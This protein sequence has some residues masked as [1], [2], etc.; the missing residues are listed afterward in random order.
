MKAPARNGTQSRSATRARAEERLR[1]YRTGALAPGTADLKRLVHELEVHQIELEMQNEQLRRTQTELETTRERLA[2]L[3]DAAPVGY[4]TID[5]SG[6]VH[7][8]N[9]TAARLLGCPRERLAGQGLFRFIAPESRDTF[10]FFCQSLAET[11][12]KRTVELRFQR[13]DRSTF[14]GW[15]ESHPEPLTVDQPPRF[16]MALSDITDRIK[17]QEN[18]TQLAAIVESSNDAIISRTLEDVIVSW[19]PACERILGYSAQEMVGR[20]F[21]LLVPPDRQPNLQTI[22]QRILR[23]ERVEQYETARIT[24]DGRRIAVTTTTSPIKDAQ[25]RVVG[26]SAILR[27]ITDQNWVEAAL[28]QSEAALADFFEQAPLGLLWV[29]PAGRILR[30]NQAQLVMLGQTHKHLFGRRLAEFSATP[31]LVPLLLERLARR[32][33]LQEHL[34]QLRYRDGSL[35]HVLIHANGFWDKGKMLHSRWFVRDVTRQV[36]LE[37]EI[38][39]IGERMQQRIG[40]DLHDDLCQQ[41]TSIEFLARSLERQLFNH[42]PAGAARAREVTQLTRQAITHTRELA[43]GMYPVDLGTEGPAGALEELAARTKKLFHVD[44]RF[45]CDSPV[46]F[47]DEAS[48][49][50]LYRIAQEA[51]G[52]AIKRGKATRIDLRLRETGDQIILSVRDNG[53]GFPNSMDGRKGLGLRIMQYRAGV[54]RGALSLRKNLKGGAAVICSIPKGMTAPIKGTKL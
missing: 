29:S 28:R 50:H 5:S 11:E 36:E 33:A 23:G 6:L 2:L 7:E 31:E 35:R 1:Q 44:C 21:R 48:Q 40:Q 30:V 39:A 17:A 52:N 47:Q 49:T 15:L 41:L 27:D 14:V 34:A 8:A 3:Y 45:R 22:R 42:A 19:N 32:E 9:L 18:I 38:L 24:K 25:G 53:V 46:R 37:K 43:H 20:P 16:L 10:H 54:I 13:S 26:I 51:V 4:L 12:D